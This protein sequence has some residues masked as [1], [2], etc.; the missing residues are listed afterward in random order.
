MLQKHTQVNAY[1]SEFR[2]S[3]PWVF[4][5]VSLET[6]VGIL[7]SIQANRIEL[8]KLRGLHAHFCSVY[9]FLCYKI[10]PHIFDTNSYSWC[11][12]ECTR[13]DGLEKSDAHI[14][15]RLGLHCGKCKGVLYYFLCRLY[16]ACAWY[17]CCFSL[18]PERR[19]MN[20]QTVRWRP[21][22]WIGNL[23]VSTFK[24]DIQN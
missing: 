21:W 1:F 6:S 13:C 3:I 18:I 8:V 12:S 22:R 16:G 11:F 24:M 15:F 10:I 2:E 23:L 14:K 4:T 7:D 19:V 5:H 17:C 20:I 9:Y